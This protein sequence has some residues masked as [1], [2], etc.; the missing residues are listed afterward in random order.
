MSLARLS[1]RKR[2]FPGQALHV[3]QETKSGGHDADGLCGSAAPLAH[4]AVVWDRWFA[5][6]AACYMIA[7]DAGRVE[8]DGARCRALHGASKL[9]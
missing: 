4:C 5:L 7:T 6:S 3:D 2:T 1:A 9:A 8:G